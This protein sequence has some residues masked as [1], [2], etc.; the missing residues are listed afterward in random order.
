MNIH[1]G[2]FV[3]HCGWNST[4]EADVSGAPLV[5]IPLWADQPTIAKYAESAWGMGVRVQK[6]GKLWLETME[7]KR[8]IRKVL[9]KD[10]R[11]STKENLQSGCKRPR[12]Q[13]GKEEAQINILPTSLRKYLS[14]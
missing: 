12:M 2:R 7:A 3:A 6:G 5:G 11:M 14:T 10:R 4:L 1:V 9:D 13:R 8:C